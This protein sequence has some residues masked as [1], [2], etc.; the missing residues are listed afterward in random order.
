M[1]S[2]SVTANIWIVIQNH[3]LV[4]FIIEINLEDFYSSA[5]HCITLKSITVKSQNLMAEAASL[6]ASSKRE[7]ATRINSEPDFKSI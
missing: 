7:K 2:K 6:L 1:Y 3:S 4:Q 5:S